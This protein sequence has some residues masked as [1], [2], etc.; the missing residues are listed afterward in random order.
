MRL[1]DVI[2]VRL[3]SM[4]RSIA[5]RNIPRVLRNVPRVADTQSNPRFGHPSSPS[6]SRSAYLTGQFAAIP[7]P[8]PGAPDTATDRAPLDR[9]TRLAARMLKAPTALVTLVEPDRQRFMAS[10][11]LREP[12]ASRQETPLT[13]SFCQHV[14]ATEAPLMVPDARLH[15]VLCENLAIRDLGVVSYLGVPLRERNGGVVGSFCVIDSVPRTWSADDQSLLDDLAQAVMSELDNERAYAVMAEATGSY[16][17][18]LDTTTELVC[19]ADGDGILTYVN[20]AWSQAFGYSKSEALGMRAVDLVSIEH[21]TRFVDVARRLQLGE[22][23]EAFEVVAI[24][25]A[26]RRVV[27]RGNATALLERDANGNERCVGTRAVYRDVTAERLGEASRARLVATLEATSDFVGIAGAGG[28]IEYVNTAGRRLIGVAEDA[29]LEH[30]SADSFHPPA[31]LALLAEEGFPAAMRDGTWRG[32]GQL[33]H[34]DGTEIPVSIAMTAHP[35]LS[36]EQPGFFAAIMRDMRTDAAAAAALQASEARFRTIF[37]SAAVGVTVVGNDG[38]LLEV[39]RAFEQML[40]YE[41]GALNGRYAPDLSPPEEREQ[42]RVPVASVRDGATESV[43]V[44]KRFLTATGDERILSLTISRLATGDGVDAILGLATDITEQRRAESGLRESEERYRRLM[45]LL[46]DGV[47]KHTAGRIQF[48]NAAMARLVGVADASELVG[49]AVLDLVHADDHALVLSQATAAVEDSVMA[50][51]IEERV[52]RRDGTEVVCEMVGTP[53]RVR[54]K[55]GMLSVVRDISERRRSEQA[56][57]EREVQL[58]AIYNHVSDA[59][60]YMRVERDANGAINGY[61]CESVNQPLLAVTG[62]PASAFVGKSLRDI[63]PPDRYAA[64]RA[65]YDDAARTGQAQRFELTT[66]GVNGPVV[67][68]TTLTPVRDAAERCTHVLGA[69]RDVTGRRAAEAALQQSEAGFRTMLQTLRAVA[70]TLDADG[71]ITFVND[72]L[73]TLTGWKREEV[74]GG[75][76]F[77]RF[78]PAPDVM[79]RLFD[80]MIGGSDFIPHYENELVT[81]GGRRRLIVWDNTVLRDSSGSIIGTASIGQDVTEQRAMEAQLASISIHDELTGLLNRRGFVGKVEDALRRGRRAKFTDALLYI[82]MDRFKPIN[83]TYGHA[84][85]DTALRAMSEVLRSTIRETDV[86]GRLGGD[87][88]A[89][90]AAGLESPEAATVLANRL[91]EAIAEHNAAA[92]RDGRPYTIGFSVGIAWIRPEDTRDTLFARADESLYAIKRARRAAETR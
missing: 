41:P 12:Y 43:T 70:V 60:F 74:V 48:A 35:S 82:D 54:G 37:E 47:I 15:P 36:P 2:A 69:N 67:F 22:D 81:R 51:P 6:V 62:R 85:G 1:V 30:V 77:T 28:Q 86:A 25:V 11:G 24:G 61:R 52:V 57:R 76:W 55:A 45:N 20:Q 26:G 44:D 39:N 40:G 49:T 65:R 83:D 71:R 75:D 42:S 78:T 33:R 7:G 14:V 31:T 32:N 84:A 79:R 23:V 34:A 8:P 91:Q 27:C 63:I 72:A 10:V 3:D 73:L 4:P 38:T 5:S 19:A 50:R 90:Y 66:V 92:S 13:H 89:I 68:E 53:V 21:R 80:G 59:M 87:E 64:M 29:P 18:L 16:R 88:F 58:N 46:P 56:L 9:L 17:A